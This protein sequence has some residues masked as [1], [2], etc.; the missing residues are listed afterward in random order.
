[1]VA[2]ELRQHRLAQAEELLRLGVRQSDA[3]FVYTRQDG[4]P[5]Q[6]RSLSQM[7]ASCATHLPRVRFHDLRARQETTARFLHRSPR[8]ADGD[9]IRVFAAGPFRL[10]L[11]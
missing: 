11:D 7:W 1:M 8:A 4:E 10:R 2:T 9:R 5:M 3:T 6:P